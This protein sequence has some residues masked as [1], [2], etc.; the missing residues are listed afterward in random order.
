MA[1]GGFGSMRYP[2]G[3][4]P[5]LSAEIYDAGLPS[6][7]RAVTRKAQTHASGDAEDVP[8]KRARTQTT[9]ASEPED[10]KKRSRGRPRLDTKDETAADVSD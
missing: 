3:E 4:L 6:R 8:R 7:R 1:G 9:E 10:E 2:E 5:I